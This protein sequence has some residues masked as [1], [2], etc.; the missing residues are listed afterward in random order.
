VR[1]GTPSGITGL[2]DEIQ[3]PSFAATVG[4]IL[5]GVGVFK[6]NSM[7]SFDKGRGN[8]SLGFTKVVDKLKSFLP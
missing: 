8:M 2:I 4:S 5:Y 7:L 6:S 3:G 1:I